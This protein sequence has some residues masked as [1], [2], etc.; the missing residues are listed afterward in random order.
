M[1][2]DGFLEKGRNTEE[3]LYVQTQ[4]RPADKGLSSEESCEVD[5]G[6]KG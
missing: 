3:S 5:R 6:D 4:P 2:L 1:Y